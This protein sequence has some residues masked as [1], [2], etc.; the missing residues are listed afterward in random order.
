MRDMPRP[1]ARQG[2]VGDERPRTALHT[3]P[4]LAQNQLPAADM[5]PMPD[6]PVPDMTGPAYLDYMADLIDELRAISARIGCPR[7]AL[8]LE[9]AHGEAVSQALARR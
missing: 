2:E 5:L 8:A 6:V 9:L 4:T 7:L 1:D 3:Q